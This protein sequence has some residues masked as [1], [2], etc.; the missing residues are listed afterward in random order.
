MKPPL[1]F[2]ILAPPPPPDVPLIYFITCGI[3]GDLQRKS[4]NQ[5]F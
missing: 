4:V 5:G 3:L 1:Q 2:Q